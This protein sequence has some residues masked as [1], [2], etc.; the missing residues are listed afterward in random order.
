M[1]PVRLTFDDGPDPH[2]TPAILDVLAAAG[3]RASFFVVGRAVREH[4]ELVR[5]LVAAGHLVANHSWSH[6]HPWRIPAA[7]ARRQVLLGH[8]AI[9]DV[10]GQAS[11]FF[12][13]PYGRRRRA[14]LEAAGE[15]GETVVLWTLSGVDW[16][17]LGRAPAIGARLSRTRPGEI[18]LLHDGRRR[19]NRPD[20]T[21]RVLPAFLSAAAARGLTFARLDEP[22]AAGG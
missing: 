16:G 6:R 9:A 11:R 1:R 22:A 13:P 18:I 17:P 21:A 20:Q 4:P 8:Q 5:R 15:L 14:Q 2:S 10:T 7:E 3:V 12:R 19:R